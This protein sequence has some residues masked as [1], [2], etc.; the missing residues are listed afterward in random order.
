[1]SA[2]LYLSSNDFD[3]VQGQKGRM[4]CNR[5]R[6][7]SLLLFFSNACHHC[8][9]LIPIF[10][11]L[12]GTIA[13]CQ[14]GLINVSA[15]KNCVA[16]SRGTLSEIQYVPYIVMYVDGKPVMKYAGPYEI[17]EIKRFVLEVSKRIKS[18]QTFANSS[19]VQKDPRGGIPAYTLG[20]PLYGPDNKVC[21]LKWDSAYDANRQ[22]QQSPQTQPGQGG[23]AGQPGQQQYHPLPAASGMGNPMMG[24]HQQQMNP[25]MQ[26]HMQQQVSQQQRGGNPNNP[27]G[28]LSGMS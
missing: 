24:Q 13:G 8:N 7:F 3:V 21:Y 22:K 18:K 12:P 19:A 14:F 6:G 17:N 15:D 20:K 27:Y 4:M 28:N 25:H 9:E 2:L 16:M 23:Y 11:K 5:I 26:Q 10:A 1:M